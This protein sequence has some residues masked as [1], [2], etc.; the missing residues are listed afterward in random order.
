MGA[1]RSLL[2]TSDEDAEGPG[3]PDLPSVS[4]LLDVLGTH[5]DTDAEIL[6]F[7]R[8]FALLGPSYCALPPTDVLPLPDSRVGHIDW[9]T[10]LY[11][12]F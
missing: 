3:L 11:V 7:L 1:L 4:G 5:Q 9:C 2:E 12:P 6:A 10:A 8:D